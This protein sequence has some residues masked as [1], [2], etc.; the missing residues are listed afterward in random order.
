MR[1]AFLKGV[2]PALG[3]VMMLAAFARSALD[4][5]EPD[6]GTTSFD[7]IGGVFLLGVGSILRRGVDAA[8]AAPLPPL[9]HHRPRTVALDH[10]RRED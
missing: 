5:I 6:Y 3:A 8:R 7:G 9:L 2:L 4:M 10:H 1:D